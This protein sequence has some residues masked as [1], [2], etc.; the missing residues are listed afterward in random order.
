[1]KN[2]IAT[3][4]TKCL[5]G[6]TK[7]SMHYQLRAALLIQSLSENHELSHVGWHSCECEQ[8]GRTI[9]QLPMTCHTYPQLQPIETVQHHQHQSQ[10]ISN[11][12]ETCKITSISNQPHARHI[13]AS[14][15]SPI[16]SIFCTAHIVTASTQVN[17]KYL[18]SD[19]LDSDDDD[20]DISKI[21][22]KLWA[23]ISARNRCKPCK[24]VTN[25]K[26]S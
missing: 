2:N 4:N 18:K 10:A 3:L 23:V 20:D 21:S 19:G 15:V 13:I 17:Q 5:Y 8:H 22:W 11:K 12:L 1:M 14:C 9:L 25:C 7:A 16:L 26:C 6:P 24:Q